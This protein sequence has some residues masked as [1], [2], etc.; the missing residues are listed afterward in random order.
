M[1]IHVVSFGYQLFDRDV[2]ISVNLNSTLRVLCLNNV[3]DQVTVLII[4]SIFVLVLL[5]YIIVLLL[6][7]HSI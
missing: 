6:K 7:A 5:L 2:L 1:K 4:V 3:K